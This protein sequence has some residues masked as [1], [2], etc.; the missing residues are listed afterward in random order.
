[1][2]THTYIHTHTHI[3][4]SVGPFQVVTLHGHMV[5]SYYI[6]VAQTGFRTLKINLS[7]FM[8]I[9]NKEQNI[10]SLKLALGF[11]NTHRPFRP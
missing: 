8:S 6:A 4:M 9:L 3:Q 1:M 7:I 10:Y 2:Y 5:Y 11:G